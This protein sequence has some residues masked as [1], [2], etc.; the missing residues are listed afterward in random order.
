MNKALDKILCIPLQCTGCMACVNSCRHQAITVSTDEKG[1][2]RPSTNEDKCINCGVCTDVCPV[3]QTDSLFSPIISTYACWNKDVQIRRNSSSGGL[4]SAIAHSIIQKGGIVYG[5]KLGPEMEAVVSSS[6][7][8]GDIKPFMGSKYIQCH[9]Y[10]HTF[11]DVKKTLDA[12]RQVLY[13]GTPCQIA[14][15]KKFLRKEYDNLLT[16][17]FLC[18]GVPSPLLFKEYIKWIENR[19]RKKIINFQFRDKKRSWHLFNMLIKFDDG[20]YCEINRDNDCFYYLF[21]NN[22]TLQNSCFSCLYARPERVSDIT[23]ADY[24]ININQMKDDDKGIS[25]SIINSNKG[26]KIFEQ[27]K[28]AIQYQPLNREEIIE[29]YHYLKYP[30]QQPDLYQSFWEDYKKFGLA[31]L[32]SQYVKKEWIPGNFLIAHSIIRHGSFTH[33]LINKLYYYYKKI[34]LQKK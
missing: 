11:R 31:V 19:Y 33:R 9:I 15:L 34:W 29:K 27:C 16:M 7:I 1:F 22:F 18:H 8:E 32:F 12:G 4:F 21:L 6:D 24:W 23:M 3:L 13:T 17:D 26:K 2:Y 25:L 28:D 14:G 10:S 30:S 5:V 20:T